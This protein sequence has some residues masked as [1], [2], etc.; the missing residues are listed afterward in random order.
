[1]VSIVPNQ[2]QVKGRIVSIVEKSE[3]ENFCQI[4]LQ[5]EKVERTKGPEGLISPASKKLSVWI[6]VEQVNH[7][8]L[9]EGQVIMMHV[10]RAP[11]RI[12]AIPDTIQI[13]EA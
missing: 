6:P 2:Y 1:M 3:L 13:L 9:T 10:R 11:D 12:F 5:L 8:Q 7:Y 4:S